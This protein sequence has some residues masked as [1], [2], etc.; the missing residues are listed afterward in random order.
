MLECRSFLPGL[1]AIYEKLF[2]Y[3]E[4]KSIIP[5]FIS[6]SLGFYF[7]LIILTAF[8]GFEL[9]ARGMAIVLANI[10]GFL[11]TI[12]LGPMVAVRYAFPY[13]LA[14]PVLY[15]TVVGNL[16]KR[17]NTGIGGGGEG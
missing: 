15:I 8:I 10:A 17:W 13:V 16:A 5:L 14:V 12:F 9:K 1:K 2:S 3:N 7:W 11:L 6:C 4:Y